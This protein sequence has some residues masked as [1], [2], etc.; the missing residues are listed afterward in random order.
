MELVVNLKP[1]YKCEKN[2]LQYMLAS[3]QA[4]IQMCLKR[5]AYQVIEIFSLEDTLLAS[6][7]K[8]TETLHN[9]KDSFKESI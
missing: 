6:E 5:K 8:Y 2:M 7:I 3:P 4:L 1:P 9:L